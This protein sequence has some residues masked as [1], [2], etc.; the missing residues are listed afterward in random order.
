MSGPSSDIGINPPSGGTGDPESPQKS[1][2]P[3]TSISVQSFSPYTAE[4]RTGRSSFQSSYASLYQD[5]NT[6][7]SREDVFH[8]TSSNNGAAS[9][10]R[11]SIA[12]SLLQSASGSTNTLGQ[13][14][15][16]DADESVFP[17]VAVAPEDTTVN[18]SASVA[19]S[20]TADTQRRRSYQR[21]STDFSRPKSSLS[22]RSS[23]GSATED[24][25]TRLRDAANA[26]A[27]RSASS[28]RRR[29]SEIDQLTQSL[30]RASTPL[31]HALEDE[32]PPSAMALS[33]E[34]PP[35][36][37][38]NRAIRRADDDEE[39]SFIKR[40]GRDRGSILPPAAF[41]AP[42]KPSARNSSSNLLAS[43]SPGTY[44][45]SNGRST[46]PISFL[47]TGG[48]GN[49]TP[50]FPDGF[51]RSSQEMLNQQQLASSP[52]FGYES[53]N[54]QRRPS[55]P[56]GISPSIHSAA[57]THQLGYYAHDARE[58]SRTHF[59]PGP[60]DSHT[61]VPASPLH[62]Q[63]PAPRSGVRLMASTDPL[64]PTQAIGNN[65]YATG[66]ANGVTNAHADG[67]EGINEKP[68][69]DGAAATSATLAP[70][71][72]SNGTAA[73]AKV[74][75]PDAASTAANPDGNARPNQT[76]AAANKGPRRY[77]S[78]KGENRFLLGGLLMT[79]TDN[80]ISF[81]LSY[82][83]LLTLG[84]LFY[85][86]EV[87]WLTRNLSPAIP[88]V[89][90]YVYLLAVVNM[91]VTA[92]KDPGVLPRD[93]DQD[94]PCVLGDSAYEDG[95]QPLADPEDPLAI[96][97]QRM[98]RIRN[99]TVKCKWCE[100]CGT[101]RPPRTSHCRVCDNCVENI[102]HHCTFLNTCIG[103]R[104]YVP[105]IAF[106]TA[107]IL[108][109]VMIIA[110]TVVHLV[111]LTKPTTYRYPRG[112]G[113]GFAPGYNF[114]DALKHS[115]VSAVL[116]LLCI[117]GVA[118]VL[119]L[120][121]YHVRLILLNRSTVE[122]IRINTAREY[123]E[124][125]ELD[126]DADADDNASVFGAADANRRRQSPLSPLLKLIGLGGPKYKDPNPFATR[127]MAKNV[128]N[129][130][131]WRSTQLESWIDRRGR[132]GHDTRQLHPRPRPDQTMTE[133][134]PVA[135]T[136]A[137]LQWKA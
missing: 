124:H 51:S 44:P 70:A 92:W 86:F 66:N 1:A 125:K 76:T 15:F 131:G 36:A 43:A 3:L 109:A 93:L 27:F 128:R 18:A 11:P 10:G 26:A 75:G 115:P 17:S 46:T 57:S 118:P 63:Q 42:K 54:V 103:R 97:V 130:L 52:Y 94:P 35:S 104:N 77:R 120:F 55:S 28:N 71:G 111:L 38:H 85:G 20:S 9:M 14:A 107:T 81:I 24:D 74:N 62:V 82:A 47:S 59:G 121:V 22:Q 23:I 95:R 7:F 126:L 84:G 12:H 119:T 37:N 21:R 60:V 64:L 16:A 135:A 105:F 127:K 136:S 132:S 100:T 110:F 69:V 30:S 99:Q 80:P 2:H 13:D 39:G 112:A 87:P 78:H 5:A 89:F 49:S 101:Y 67:G 50:A 123:G 96:P 58:G 102:D 6:S 4:P 68:P 116:F 129:G 83:L 122:Q 88:A 56:W 65:P 25:N 31:G 137:G 106:L 34:R 113:D 72:K 29:S 45:A 61:S 133:P 53:P 91:G 98:L 79:S 40:D 32:R 73:N 108:S 8:D 33:F 48:A 134:G 114:R 117:A 19:G 90:S 41:F